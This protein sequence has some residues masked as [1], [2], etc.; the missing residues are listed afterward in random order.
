MK[1]SRKKLRSD[2]QSGAHSST[3]PLSLSDS[4]LR[5][6]RGVLEDFNQMAAGF[7]KQGDCF[8]RSRGIE[9]LSTFVFLASPSICP[10][11]AGWQIH[12][13]GAHLC[14]QNRRD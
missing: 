8:Y 4:M 2:V 13:P 10:R 6:L 9:P 7:Q 5:A 12:S 1:P 3:L 11:T 14:V